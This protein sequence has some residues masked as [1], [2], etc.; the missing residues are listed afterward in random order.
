MAELCACFVACT[1]CFACLLDLA[2]C[3]CALSCSP[4]LLAAWLLGFSHMW[5]QLFRSVAPSVVAAFIGT[6][7]LQRKYRVVFSILVIQIAVFEPPAPQEC[8]VHTTTHDADDQDGSDKEV[9]LGPLHPVDWQ[10]L[11]LAFVL[12]CLPNCGKIAR[13]G[14]RGAAWCWKKIYQECFNSNCTDVDEAIT[15]THLTLR[16]DWSTVLAREQ[17][18]TEQSLARL[19]AFQS[20]LAL[21]RAGQFA[22][23]DID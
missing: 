16:A 15:L 18:V 8:P 2:C 7:D 20:E 21:L 13:F 12:R 14:F 19:Q 1:S 3:R 4:A 6:A 11:R 9:I 23:G 17:L 10:L 22:L 5:L